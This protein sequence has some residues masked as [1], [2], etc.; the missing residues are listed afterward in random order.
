[1]R[2]MNGSKF[3]G[4]GSE[5]NTGTGNLSHRNIDY[6]N[7]H[8][9]CDTNNNN[10]SPPIP[11]LVWSFKASVFAVLARSSRG[12]SAGVCDSLEDGSW[13]GGQS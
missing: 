6:Q 4:M 3:A 2:N 10:I 1:M 11:R 12:A 9:N 7:P 5:E 13:Q 8:W